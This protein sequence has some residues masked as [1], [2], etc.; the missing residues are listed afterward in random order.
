MTVKLPE[1][2]SVKR[3]VV[4]EHVLILQRVNL[5]LVKMVL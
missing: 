3:N 1:E 5:D 4:N 2:H